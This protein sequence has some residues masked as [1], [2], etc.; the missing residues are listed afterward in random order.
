MISQVIPR[1]CGVGT[2][3]LVVCRPGGVVSRHID[4][5]PSSAARSWTCW[6]PEGRWRS[7]LLILVCRTRLFAYAISRSA[8]AS[9]FLALIIQVSHTPRHVTPVQPEY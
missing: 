8:S 2:I 7:C 4:I 6:L 9:L 1:F 3:E 5:H